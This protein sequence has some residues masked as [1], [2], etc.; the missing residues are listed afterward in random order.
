[1][2]FEESRPPQPIWSA[3]GEGRHVGQVGGRG[4]YGY[5]KIRIS[6]SPLGSGLL[7][8]NEIGSEAIPTAF[9]PAVEQALSEAVRRGV[10]GGFLIPDFATRFAMPRPFQARRVTIM[11]P[12]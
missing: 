10:H 1:M 11:D 9:I 6:P 2:A 5:V 7:L 12:L 8:N 4:A 3:I